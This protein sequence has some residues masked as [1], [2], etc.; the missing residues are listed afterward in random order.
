MK[1]YLI[2]PQAKTV[3]EVHYNG[4]FH[5]I[6]ELIEVELFTV[7]TIDDIGNAVF[8]DDEGLLNNPRY[9]FKLAGYLQPLAGKGLVLGTDDD[10]ESV[11]PTISLED[12]RGM[13]SFLE[14]SVQGFVESDTEEE[15]AFGKCM[16]SAQRLSSDL[17]RRSEP[18]K[19][20]SRVVNPATLAVEG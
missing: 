1:A 9:F 12:V 10:G 16:C 14:A 13:V 3:T 18:K 11:E 7:V 17:P 4:D 5:Q 15:T 19:P 8:I 20:D 2:D 6:Y